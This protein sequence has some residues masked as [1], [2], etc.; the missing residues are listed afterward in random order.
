MKK[1]IVSAVVLI[2]TFAYAQENDTINKSNNIDE[3]ILNKYYKKYNEKQGSS[4]L[5][6]DEE[7]IKI[8]QNISVI[9]N[10]ALEDQ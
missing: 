9:T 1:L 6:L 2:S 3:V 5:R 8:P 7:L 4:S 10:K